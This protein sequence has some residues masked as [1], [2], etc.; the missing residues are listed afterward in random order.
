M[1]VILL[2]AG[3]HAARRLW[4]TLEPLQ[5]FYVAEEYHQDYAARNPYQPYISYVAQP[6]VDSL[7]K[8]FPEKLKN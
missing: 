4:T 8:N 1:A 7:R 6:K 2:N 5:A 3:M